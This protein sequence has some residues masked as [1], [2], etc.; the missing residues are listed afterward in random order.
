MKTI[1]ILMITAAIIVMMFVFYSPI[2]NGI[3]GSNTDVETTYN[4]VD[5]KI[6]KVDEVVKDNS[7]INIK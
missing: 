4:Y 6:V 3:T 2:K 7:K 1:R 5:G